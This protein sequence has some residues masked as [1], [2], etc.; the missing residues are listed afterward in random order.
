MKKKIEIKKKK[1]KPLL[2]NETNSYRKESKY[3]I[4]STMPMMAGSQ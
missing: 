2:T 3:K 4:H 1:K